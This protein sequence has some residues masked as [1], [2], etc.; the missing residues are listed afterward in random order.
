MINSSAVATAYGFS[1]N[2]CDVVRYAEMPDGSVMFG[3]ESD[4]KRQLTIY[5]SPKGKSVRVFRADKE[6]K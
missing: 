1:W 5:V 3:V 4:E 2:A 6:L